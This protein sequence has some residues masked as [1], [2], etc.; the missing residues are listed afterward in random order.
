LAIY[1]EDLSD[2]FQ[3]HAFLLYF[4]REVRQRTKN[5]ENEE[6]KK[7]YVIVFF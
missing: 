3:L 1:T 6:E 4:H 2:A 7:K 5:E